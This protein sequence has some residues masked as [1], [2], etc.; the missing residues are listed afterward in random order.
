MKFCQII[1]NRIHKIYSPEEASWYPPGLLDLRELPDEVQ[2]GWILDGDIWR[3]PRP[4][5]EPPRPPSI[6]EQFD[7]LITAQTMLVEGE[8]ATSLEANPEVA[9]AKASS[10]AHVLSKPLQWGETL[11]A[12]CIRSYDGT[13]YLVVAAQV[14]AMEY[15]PPDMPNGAMLAVYTPLPRMGS[16]G[17]YLWRYGEQITS[18]GVRREDQGKLWQTLQGAGANIFRPSEVPA[19]WQLISDLG[20]GA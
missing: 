2:E 16:N 12:G 8:L 19:I 6:D 4:E 18:A 11:Y 15:Q 7:R 10:I 13:D 1:S 5:D 14:I 3:E 20:G 17:Y 9:R